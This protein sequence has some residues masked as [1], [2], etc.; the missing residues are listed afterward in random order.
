MPGDYQARAVDQLID[1]LFTGLPALM[2]V[3][4]RATGKTTTASRH[5]R[6]V[7]KLDDDLQGA[8]FRRDP[9]RSL[10]AE[11]EPVLLDEWQSAPEVL[12]AVKRTLD[13]EPTRPGRFLL[14]GSVNADLEA[15]TWPGTGRVVR[16][17]MYGMTVAEQHGR[18]DSAFLDRVVAD[19][20]PPVP[21]DPPDLRGYVQLALQ[22]GFPEALRPGLTEMQQERWLESYVEQLVTRDAR[23]A[24]GPRDPVLLRR[25]LEAFALNSAG[26]TESKRLYDAA[27]IT[28][29]T[30]VDY[31]QL[32]LNLWVVDNLPAWAPNRFKRL[33]R[34]PKRY[35]VD[36][37]L[38]VAT[39]RLG[40]DD[41]LQDGNLLGRVIDTFVASQLRAEA[42]W[43][44]SRPRLFH[45]RDQDGRH[46]VDLVAELRGRKVVG[47][48][49]KASGS[50]GRDA[51]KHLI[52]LRDQ[53]GKE[54]HRGIVLHTGPR[55]YEL[56]DRIVAMPIASLW[57]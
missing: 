51:A 24:A 16:V 35:V 33:V 7:V 30:G 12:G 23:K 4:P 56:D 20:E 28:R 57:R 44:K 49:V 54:F 41:V 43:A 25:F 53:M 46:E 38:M 39:L 50:P 13:A 15:E 10:S 29:P 27:G 34:S 37:G 21:K 8:A 17:P 6:T 36:A 5:A 26:I 2:L 1:E 19:D 11:A 31:E 55:P 42:A 40:V 22:S 52:W 32:L 9:D 45:L 48:E 3:G 14:T 47:I 18:T